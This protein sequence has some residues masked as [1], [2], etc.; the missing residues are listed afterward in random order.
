MSQTYY[1]ILEVS[2]NASQTVIAAAYRT[3]S[4]KYHPDKNNGDKN[5]EDMM[6]KINVAFGV[7]SD[8]IKRK[9][10]DEEIG[11]TKSSH[12]S[13]QEEKTKIEPEIV[14]RKVNSFEEYAPHVLGLIVIIGI[15]FFVKTNSDNQIETQ[16]SQIAIPVSVEENKANNAW[17]NAESLLTGKGQ[18]QNYLKALEEY[19]K[20]CDSKMFSDGRA[21]QRIAEIYFYGLGQNKDYTKAMEWYKRTKNAESEYMIGVMYLEGLG[22]KKDLIKAYYYFN[23]LQVVHYASG[24]DY[25]FNPLITEQ[26]RKFIDIDGYEGLIFT[27]LYG[28]G[29]QLFAVSAGVK[30]K[31]LEKQLTV[32]EI[33]QAQNLEIAD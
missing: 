17:Q 19:R 15:L 25:S 12:N 22:V 2:P 24:R 23:K 6:A 3:L 29:S 26:Q 13:K 31:L 33:N 8:S 20:I 21:E 9:L 14:Q 5:C 30:K 16:P 18:S 7:L 10:Y 1:D 28:Y 27:E 32:N 11:L 4:Q